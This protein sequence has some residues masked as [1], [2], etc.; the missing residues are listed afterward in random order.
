[1]DEDEEEARES[2]RRRPDNMESGVQLHWKTDQLSVDAEK[3]RRQGLEEGP[4]KSATTPVGGGFDRDSAGAGGSGIT[5]TGLNGPIGERPEA[6]KTEME[7]EQEAA[8]EKQRKAD[9]K[10]ATDKK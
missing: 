4:K 3:L 5:G 2:I 7:R 8:A 10:K 9:E 6:N 1:M